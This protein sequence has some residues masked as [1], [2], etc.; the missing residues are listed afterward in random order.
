MSNEILREVNCPNC[1]SPIDVRE[2]GQHV[3]CNACDSQFILAGHLCPQ[4]HAYY[5]SEVAV[6]GQC[7]S[8]VTRS[9]A[10]CSTSNWAGDEYC[11]NC[12]ASLDIF[13]VITRRHHEAFN[14]H[15]ADQRHSIRD[16]KQKEELDSLK[17]WEEIMSTEDERQAEIRRRMARRRAQDRRTLMVAAG[18]IVLFL[19]VIGAYAILSI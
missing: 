17:R 8:P 3:R 7:S 1:L 9:C 2:H 15:R 5:D 4:C 12:A 6:C 13:D 19:V 18:L 11:V 16:L 14:A 10:K